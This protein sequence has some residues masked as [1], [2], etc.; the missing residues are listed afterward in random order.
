MDRMTKVCVQC[1]I[2]KSVD[3]FYKKRVGADGAMQYQSRCKAC[4]N[5]KSTAW[6]LAHPAYMK[7]SFKKWWNKNKNYKA[8]C[9][10][11]PEYIS[12]Q[13]ARRAS[14]AKR[15]PEKHALGRHRGRYK[16]GQLL[17]RAGVAY[18]LPE[19]LSLKKVFGNICICCGM[20]ETALQGSG[21]RLVAD[22]VI[23]VA[24]GGSNDIG[25]IQPL[26]HGKGG[27]NNRKKDKCTDFR[28]FFSLLVFA[29]MGQVL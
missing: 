17:E 25:N 13:T 21:K 24:K 10:L 23:S 20:H 14:W 5:E 26:C 6:N 27:C 7:A 9:K 28:P 1:G 19:W 12:Q 29:R 8:P 3:D 16:R 18:T 2:P 22:H 15:N 11:K 4:H